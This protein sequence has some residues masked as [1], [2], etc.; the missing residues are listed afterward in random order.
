[1][2]TFWILTRRVGE[3]VL[4]LSWSNA[5][6]GRVRAYVKVDFFVVVYSI[7]GDFESL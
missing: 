1:M 4:V 2:Y 3:Y 5:L 7:Q 6:L